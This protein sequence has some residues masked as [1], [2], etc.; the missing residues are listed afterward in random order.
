M[1]GYIS[2]SEETLKIFLTIATA[3]QIQED[4]FPHVLGSLLIHTFEWEKWPVLQGCF[5][6][7]CGTVFWRRGYI[8]PCPPASASSR[9]DTK[10]SE[11]KSPLFPCTSTF[12]FF[13]GSQ[14]ME[15]SVLCLNTLYKRKSLRTFYNF[16]CFSVAF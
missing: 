6:W 16:S 7:R 10:S 13:H 11:K 9:G 12:L 1:S 3:P 15:L 5:S 8:W 2:L 14:F 4:H